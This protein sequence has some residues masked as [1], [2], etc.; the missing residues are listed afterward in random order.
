M[1]VIEIILLLLWDGGL[2]VALRCFC[3]IQGWRFFASHFIEVVHWLDS[4]LCGLANSLVEQWMFSCSLDFNARGSQ[5]HWTFSG[6]FKRYSIAQINQMSMQLSIGWGTV[7]CCQQSR[8]LSKPGCV[9]LIERGKGCQSHNSWLSQ[10]L[11]SLFH[12]QTLLPAVCGWRA[13][14]ENI[15]LGLIIAKHGNRFN[16]TS[17]VRIKKSGSEKKRGC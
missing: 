11:L 9:V 16:S 15:Q 12:K 13:A 7:V 6:S 3:G 14:A 17:D 1:W 8:K 5:S 10:H 4:L 2:P